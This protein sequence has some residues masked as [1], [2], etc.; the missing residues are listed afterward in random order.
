MAIK[1]TAMNKAEE[2]K[3][4]AKTEY[5]RMA[6]DNGIRYVFTESELD[7][8]AKQIGRDE[9]IKERM[10]ILE[11]LVT[12]MWYTKEEIKSIS[13]AS[14]DYDLAYGYDDNGY[15]NSVS[16]IIYGRTHFDYKI[17]DF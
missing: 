1:P 4:K 12:R 11:D 9:I 17:P 8:Y 6:H 14:E 5:F 7:E 16:L 10:A 13:E 3:Q 15:P 2:L